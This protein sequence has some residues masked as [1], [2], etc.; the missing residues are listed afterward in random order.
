[1]TPPRPPFQAVPCH[2]CVLRLGTIRGGRSRRVLR[3]G[4]A[5]L[6]P[7]R[8]HALRQ[9]LR[10]HRAGQWLTQRRRGSLYFHRRAVGRLRCLLTTCRV[11]AVSAEATHLLGHF[12]VL[13]EISDLRT[14]RRKYGTDR[15]DDTSLINRISPSN[16]PRMTLVFANLC[17]K[18][19]GSRCVHCDSTTPRIFQ[20]SVPLSDHRADAVQSRLSYG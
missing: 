14:S 4:I 3:H 6:S 10:C 20:S 15:D 16:P 2:A 9:V 1:M 11:C 13:Y 12:R 7:G 5:A 19:M 8:G 18:E 17:G